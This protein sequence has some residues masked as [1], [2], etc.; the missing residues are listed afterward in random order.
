MDKLNNSIHLFFLA[1]KII[2]YS[3]IVQKVID[4]SSIEPN[5]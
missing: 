5:M 3:Y 1:S 4:T 2:F